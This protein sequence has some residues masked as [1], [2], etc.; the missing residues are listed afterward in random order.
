MVMRTWTATT[1]GDRQD[2]YLRTVR[3][4]VLPHLASVPGYLGAFFSRRPVGDSW[5]YL[6]I[7]CW[8]SMDAVRALAGPD[9]GRAYVP[10]EVHET[11]D[12]WDASVDHLEVVIA[13]ETDRLRDI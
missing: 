3:E 9:P 7:S 12:R 5:E 8:E 2:D 1:D 6:V 10:P 13:H 11:L 4:Q